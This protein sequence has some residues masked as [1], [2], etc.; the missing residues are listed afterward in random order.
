MADHEPPTSGTKHCP[1]C[2]KTKSVL[3]FATA[4]SNK[5]G[6]KKTCRECYNGEHTSS[7]SYRQL[8]VQR[9]EER[10]RKLKVAN[11]LARWT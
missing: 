9:A 10:T 6:L 5:D 4:R 8:Q 2:D 3:A 1:K 11:S 7:Q